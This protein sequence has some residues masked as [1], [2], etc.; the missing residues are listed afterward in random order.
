MVMNIKHHIDEFITAVFVVYYDR[1]IN[2]IKKA[3]ATFY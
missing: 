2:E 3:K 1:N